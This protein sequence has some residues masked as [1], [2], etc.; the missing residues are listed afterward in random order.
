[1]VKEFEFED[2]GRTFRCCVEAPTHAGLAPWWW[3]KVDGE[4]NTRHAP[5]EASPKDTVKSVR[6]RIVAY[7]AQLQAIKARPVHQ[8][9]VWQKPARPAAPAEIPAPAQAEA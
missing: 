3:F 4:G 7:Y 1:M 5:F 8:R 6:T 9:P 2:D